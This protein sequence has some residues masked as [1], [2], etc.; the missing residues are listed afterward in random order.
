VADQE[1][2]NSSGMGGI[3]A[4]LRDP[5]ILVVKVARR[6][7]VSRTTLYKYVGVTTPR[8]GNAATFDNVDTVRRSEA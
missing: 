8:N 3:K 2:E 4:L 1:D 5:D 6:Y 7:D